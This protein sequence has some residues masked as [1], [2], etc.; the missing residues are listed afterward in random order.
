Y[1]HT[2]HTKVCR[3]QRQIHSV[4]FSADI[5]IQRA[6]FLVMKKFHCLNIVCHQQCVCVRER[7]RVWGCVCVCVG[8]SH[9]CVSSF[10][11]N[12]GSIERSVV[13]GGRWM[14]FGSS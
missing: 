13:P 10:V 8:M 12:I 5:F 14:D 2:R 1:T 7:E 11:T 3:H 6:L 4:S 9:V